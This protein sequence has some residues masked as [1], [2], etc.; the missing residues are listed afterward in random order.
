[1]KILTLLVFH[2]LTVYA[3]EQECSIR[4]Q[5]RHESIEPTFDG[6]TQTLDLP[7]ITKPSKWSDQERIFFV[8]T[9]GRSFL[10]PRSACTVESALRS[11]S[12]LAMVVALT[13]KT[14]DLSHNATRHL[15]EKFGGTRLFFHYVDLDEIFSGTPIE[16]LHKSG[17]LG[18]SVAKPLAKV[19]HY[20]DAV[21]DVLVHKF[22]GF[23]SD[24]DRVFIKSPE[25]LTNSVSTDLVPYASMKTT[26]TFGQKLSNS[27]FH[28]DSGHPFLKMAIEEFSTAFDPGIGG[29]A[30]AGP[31]LFTKI[32]HRLC[33]VAEGSWPEIT[34]DRF[35]PEKCRGVTVSHPKLTYPVPWFEA[36]LLWTPR[37]SNKEWKEFFSSAV[38]IH[39]YFSSVSNKERCHRPQQYGKMKPAYAYL[40][41][42]YCPLSFW[43]E[44]EF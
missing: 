21:R 42:K 35:N 11:S 4:K 13:A 24:L 7:P 39:F 19:A 32:L 22:G 1:M 20:S 5:S 6:S 37:R 30:S 27:F 40:G 44:K 23:Y 3:L 31:D 9:S 15:Y 38:S 41:P 12:D 2:S 29:W 33:G 17:R 25:N 26:K 18:S 16:N 28:F 43:S 8:E 14:L 34:E 36:A 10:P